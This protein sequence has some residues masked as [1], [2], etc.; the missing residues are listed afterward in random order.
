MKTLRLYSKLKGSLIIHNFYI[1]ICCI[2]A[3]RIIMV[4]MKKNIA[5]VAG[6]NINIIK[7]KEHTLIRTISALLSTKKR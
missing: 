3:L 4:K 7:L 5:L 1:I 6:G 2:F